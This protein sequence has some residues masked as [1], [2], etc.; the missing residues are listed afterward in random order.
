[1]DHASVLLQ[2]RSRYLSFNTAFQKVADYYLAYPSTEYIP[3]AQVTE[4]T[5]VSKA[6]V[7]RFIQEMGYSSY[8]SF[9]M[10]LVRAN[11]IVQESTH[12]DFFGY[13]DVTA[14]DS[15]REIGRK[16][17]LSNVRALEETLELVDFS[18]LKK[19]TD[20][21]SLGG[22]VCIFASGR[23]FVTADSI[24]KRLMR[25]DIPC[26]TYNDPH[27]QAL[28][29]TMTKPNDLIIGISAFGRSASVIR[30]MRRSAKN[31]SLVIGVSSYQGTPIVKAA[32]HMIYTATSDPILHSSEPS[33]TTVTHI[34][35]F[36]CLYMMLVMKNLSQ[37][38]HLLKEGAIAMQDERLPL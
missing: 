5:G 1:M 13:A 10:D 24:R 3:I 36:D 29:S 4:V 17:F 37:V 14:S 12:D 22:Q 20:H 30:A 26:T 38:R 21:I 32:D 16:V 31:G 35:V 34:V 33:C 28:A 9:Q 19:M 27:E 23:S 15:P 25:L 7:S 11:H 6:T 8:K 2:I 18:V